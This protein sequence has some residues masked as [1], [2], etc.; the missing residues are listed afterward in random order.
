MQWKVRSDFAPSDFICLQ[1]LDPSKLPALLPSVPFTF[2][3]CYVHCLQ[4]AANLSA[5]AA[6]S[7]R[8]T[9][10]GHKGRMDDVN[11]MSHAQQPWYAACTENNRCGVYGN[12]PYKNKPVF[13]VECIPASPAPLS[14]LSCRTDTHQ[15]ICCQFAHAIHIHHDNA[16]VL[17]PLT[18][19]HCH[20]D[21]TYGCI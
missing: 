20:V 14:L 17:H 18:P 4:P 2:C 10:C 7:W 3:L 5:G 8:I 12:L 19:C 15:Y 21:L 13:G 11:G 9:G 16:L 6:V 1:V